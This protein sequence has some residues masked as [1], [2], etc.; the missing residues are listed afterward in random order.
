MD[1]LQHY[2]RPKIPD[3]DFPQFA[4]D[5]HSLEDQGIPLESEGDYNT[6]KGNTATLNSGAKP[7]HL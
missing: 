6:L 4:N 5:H 1:S 2:S 7:M 3:Q